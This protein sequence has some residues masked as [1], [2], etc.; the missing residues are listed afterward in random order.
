MPYR[1]DQTRGPSATRRGVVSGQSQEMGVLFLLPFDGN[2]A[3]ENEFPI[4]VGEGRVMCLR[5]R[6][7]GGKIQRHAEGIHYF[8]A[9]NAEG[10]VVLQ[11]LVKI[12]K[13]RVFPLVLLRTSKQVNGGFNSSTR[14]RRMDTSII[15][16]EDLIGRKNTVG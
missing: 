11:P 14:T 2:K 13:K 12:L 5:K 8:K 9:E 1:G 16:V 7:C 15:S 3:I 6:T 4:K 10:V